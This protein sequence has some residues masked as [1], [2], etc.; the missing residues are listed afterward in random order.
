MK[1]EKKI[2]LA[3]ILNLAFSVFEFF[4]GIFTG[5]VAIISDSVHDMG[6]AASIGMSYFL[7]KKSKKK[8]DK[9]YTYGYLRYSV[10]GGLITVLILL[11]GSV[12]VVYNAIDRIINPREISYDGMI[13]FAIVGAGVNLVAS[14]FTK[15]GD[16][17]NQKA[18]NLHMLEDVLGWVIVLF[19]AIII[20]FT[21]I[22]VI[23][24][25][26]SIGVA[27]F[28]IVSALKS[29]GEI[30]NLFLIKTPKNINI[31]EIKEHLLKI[32]GVMDIHHIHIW[33]IDAQSNYATMHIAVKEYDPYI[34]KQIKE[35]LK[36]HN[37]PHS[38][39]EFE[40]D[41][42]NCNE[43]ECKTESRSRHFHHHHHH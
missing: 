8:P 22:Y 19:G 28:I 31:E 4:G 37:I 42:E 6:D 41:E 30:G 40:T 33:S 32:E 3:F 5:S 7:E 15:E 35:E 1:T 9:K 20:K 17:I 25:I 23:D 10:L 29:L 26:M 13:V 21:E 38:T 18:V 12:I 39:L 11:I 14:Y 16:S 36:E 2:L 34:K 43:R 27:V 24:P